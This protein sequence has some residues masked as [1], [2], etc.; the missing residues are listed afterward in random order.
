MQ[1]QTAMRYHL[2]RFK[3]VIIKSLQILNAGQ[4]WKHCWWECK[5]LQ[6][7]LKIVWRFLKKTKSGNT[8]WFGNPIPGYIS[9]KE[10]NS[11]LKRY[12]NPKV[13][14]SSIYNSQGMEMIQV[15]INRG[16]NYEVMVYT[17]N[18]I[19]LCHNKEWTVAIWNNMDG[20]REYYT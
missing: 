9:R 1:V 7:L 19:V 3:M 5:S 10:K 16:L 11:N 12:I 8:M 17:S 15:P 18:G 4:I 6:A 20:P 13:H 14:R 2:T